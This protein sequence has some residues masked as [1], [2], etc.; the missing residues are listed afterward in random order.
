[1]ISKKCFPTLYSYKA[2]QTTKLR[3]KIQSIL[4]FPLPAVN[5]QLK[6]FLG[7]ATYLRDFVR[8]YSTISQ[9]L[10]QLLTDN[11]K[12]RRVVWTPESTA[13]FHDMKTIS[14][15]VK[16]NNTARMTIE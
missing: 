13:V 4:D 6:S 1:M 14:V 7:T 5:K 9:P 11:N 2:S 8:D 16:G 10:H 3:T 12:S 15:I